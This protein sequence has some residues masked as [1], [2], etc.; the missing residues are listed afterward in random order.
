MSHPK[1]RKHAEEPEEHENHER[2]LVSYADMITVLMAL[3]IVLFAMSS[4]DQTKFEALKE[5]LASS[6][7]KP[8]AAVQTGKTPSVGESSD[9]EG[10]LDV[11]SFT[12]ASSP[13]VAKE[14]DRAV[15]AAKARDALRAAEKSRADIEREVRSME[16][17]RKAIL[18][19]L[20]KHHLSNA[21]RFRFDERGLVISVITDKVLFAADLASLSE[22]GNAVLDAI[23]PALRVL[24]HDLL[25]EGHTNLVPVPPKYYPSEWELSGARAASVVRH[26]I[27]ADGI[28]AHRLSATAYADQHPLI[29]GTSPRA[30]RLNR[31]VEIVVAS[32]LPAAE[33]AQLSAIASNLANQG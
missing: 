33:R 22:I 17:V 3:F 13:Q 20:A 7:G 14:I 6:F 29:K 23:A 28:Q 27:S 9:Q 16:A 2:W 11:G 32:K 31:R 18:A 8:I 15:N 4:V 19:E 10:V 30:N 21:V 12:P 26:L 5:S 24:P 1:R 25:I